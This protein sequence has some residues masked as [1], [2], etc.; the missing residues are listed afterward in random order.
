MQILVIIGNNIQSEFLCALIT[1]GVFLGSVGTFMTLKM[2]SKLNLFLYMIGPAT[3]MT[4]FGLAFLLTFLNNFP[5]KN[6]KI[7]KFYWKQFVARK[8]DKRM[9]YACKPYGV[10]LGPYGMSTSRLG[11]LICDDMLQNSV[12]MLLLA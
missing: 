12:A 4:C 11:L 9:L 2:Y 7:F 1:V 10:D 6:S 3:T 5:N 8:E